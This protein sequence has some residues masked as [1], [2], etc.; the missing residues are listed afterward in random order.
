MESLKPC[1]MSVFTSC[2][3][4]L[5]DSIGSLF[6]EMMTACNNPNYQIKY[7]GDGDKISSASNPTK[8]HVFMLITA[9]LTFM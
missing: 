9:M 2:D 4:S 6:D 1:L 5:G 7:N 8:T 3:Q